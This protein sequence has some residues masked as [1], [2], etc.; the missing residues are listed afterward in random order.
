MASG[1]QSVG[2]QI[3]ETIGADTAPA[4]DFS[5]DSSVEV[6]FDPKPNGDPTRESG[7]TISGRWVQISYALIDLFLVCANGC[8]AFSIRFLPSTFQHFA[9]WHRISAGLGFSVSRYA[10]FLMLYAVL[11][12]LFCQTQNLYRTLRTPS[13]IEESFAVLKAVTLATLLLS[14]FIYLSGVKIVSR[15]VIAYAGALN[16]LTFAAWR[17]W[18][19]RIVLRRAAQGFGMRNVLIVGAGCIGQALAE[20]LEE[21]KLLGYS[22]KG[23]L[24]ANN[25][26][27]PKLLGKIEDLSRIARSEFA[28]EV[29]ITIPSERE[30]V[31]KVAIEACCH[32]LAVKVIPDLYDGLGWNAPITHVGSFPA[33]ELHWEPIPAFGLFVKRVID[34]VGST[35]GLTLLS[36]ILLA[37]SIAIRLDSSGPALYCSQRVGKKGRKFVCHKFRTMSL[38]ADAIKDQLRHLNEREGPTFKITDDPRLTRLG[39]FLRKYSLDELPQLWNVLKGDMSLVG[40]RPHPLDDYEQY[41]LEHL[42]RLDV[43][44]GITGLW[45]VTAR[46]DPSFGR[47]MELD[48]A[49]I[50]S[51]SLGK[52]LRILLRTVAEIATGSGR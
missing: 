48:V 35:I 33:I 34:V 8:L 41:Q 26:T 43:K 38:N 16:A 21:N 18:K 9:H 50:D 1:F 7:H 15:L 13:A 36:P 25:S 19:R 6:R 51:W 27:H 11:T 28:D 23:F 22:F 52:D 44:P 37:I 31:K 2:R 5:L 24:D 3:S 20:H 49:Y 17:L 30:L 42:R 12:L 4:R 45:Q 10:A 29:L 47:N 14:A 40:P 32:R 39:K 46:Q